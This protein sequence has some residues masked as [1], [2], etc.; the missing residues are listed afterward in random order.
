MKSSLPLP[1]TP[2][3]ES[4]SHQSFVTL[5]SSKTADGLFAASATGSG[6]ISSAKTYCIFDFFSEIFLPLW[7]LF[8]ITKPILHSSDGF[9]RKNH[10]PSEIPSIM[11]HLLG[12]YNCILQISRLQIFQSSTIKNWRM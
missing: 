8:G 6:L 9:P 3:G 11:L 1:V 5:T 2:S 10:P 4:A 12:C 7:G